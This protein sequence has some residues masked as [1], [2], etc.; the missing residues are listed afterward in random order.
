MCLVILDALSVFQ[1]PA[2]VPGLGIGRRDGATARHERGTAW[3]EVQRGQVVG[4][5]LGD[6]F[7]GG[8]HFRQCD[9]G[10]LW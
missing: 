3:M 1:V 7:W 2:S 9:A 10:W 5:C 8:G 6:G 4:F